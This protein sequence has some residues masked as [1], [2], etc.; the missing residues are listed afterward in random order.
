M[1][2]RTLLRLGVIGLAAGAAAGV[3]LTNR[4]RTN[5][6]GASSPST[7]VGTSSRLA[8]NARLARLG[9]TAATSLAVTRARQVFASAERRDQLAHEFELRTAE[10]VAEALGD[11]KGA[12]MKLGQMISYLDQGLPEH[13]RGALAELQADAPPMHPVLAAE[14]IAA[15]LGAR[16]ETIFET[17]DPIPIAAASIGQVH[18][19]MTH[20]GRAVAVKVQ[21]PGVA[22]AVRSDLENVGLLFGGMGTVFEGFDHRP[23]VA[24]LRERLVE[25]LDYTLEA[26]NQARFAEHYEGHPTIHVPHVVPELSGERVLTT[27]LAEGVRFEEM[28]QWGQRERD[29]VAETIYRFAFGS[30]YQLGS[31]NGDPHPGNYLFRPG[32][33]VTFLDFGL[34]KHFTPTEI[35][36]FGEMIHP[37]VIEP[38]AAA[39]RAAVERIG[40][41]RPGQ[42]FTDD[43]VIDY[44]SHFYEFVRTDGPSTITAEYASETVRRFFD[45]SGP[46]G[47]IMKA[48]NLPPSFVIINR[49]NLGLY[50]IFGDMGATANWRR[51]AEEVWPFVAGPPSTPMGEAIARWAEGRGTTATAVPTPAVGPLGPVGT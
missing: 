10:Q 43:E 46:Y 51:L 3:A 8:R 33:Q 12:L 24:E 18:R 39:F 21:Y 28:L 32:G 47:D 17:W 44:F 16:P 25:E 9:G 19:A 13:V 31:F 37:M 11:M 40:L 48:A 45:L 26:R 23:F 38:D 27:E 1:K 14:T 15:H 36:Q 42:P 7:A 35:D 22:D 4:R 50:A 20:D 6:E 2:T 49:I 29:L 41:L 34:V 5:P 30:L